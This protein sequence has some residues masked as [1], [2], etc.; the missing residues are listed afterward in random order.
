MPYPVGFSTRGERSA[1]LRYVEHPEASI[2][3]RQRSW[4][5]SHP[6]EEAMSHPLAVVLR[7][8]RRASAKHR[9]V[10]CIAGRSRKLV[11]YAGQGNRYRKPEPTCL[12]Q[13]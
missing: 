11:R 2:R 5:R 6:K 8:A 7:D 4:L 13:F 12:E 10:P 3:R 1:Y 9:W